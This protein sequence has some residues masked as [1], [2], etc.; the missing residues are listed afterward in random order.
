M[1]MNVWLIKIGEPIPVEAVCKER[2][3]RTGL[4]S[5]YLS[6]DDHKVTWWTS[7]FDRIRRKNIQDQ[8]LI[9]NTRRGLTIR[10][11][12]SPGYN[13]S[14]SMA[15]I[16][17][18]RY[19]AEKFLQCA[20]KESPPD[21]ILSAY[22]TIEL[23]KAAVLYGIQHD[24]PVV[25]DIRDLWPDIF[26]DSS[27]WFVRPLIRILIRPM[28]RDSRL[29]CARAA[30]ITGITEQFVDWGINRGGRRRTPLDRS[31][32]LAFAEATLTPGDIEESK[33]FWDGLGVKANDD[34]F[35]ICF[36]G[37]LGHQFDIDTAVLASRLLRDA[38]RRV[39]F[40]FCGSGDR[41][42]YYRR[43]AVD[44]DRIIFPGWM[45]ASRLHVLLHRASVGLNPLPDRFDFLSTINNKAIEYLSAGLPILSSPT[46]GVLNEFI[47]REKCGRSY[48]RQ[49]ATDLA[50]Q[51]GNL[52]DDP[53]GLRL[54][55]DNARRSFERHFD[56]DQ[57]YPEMIRHLEQ[58]RDSRLSHGNA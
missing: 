31:F 44:D 33:Q 47:T 22:P 40:V 56:P 34:A 50:L 24:I 15:R 55:S 45:N 37:T 11:L 35:I 18:Q 20:V 25:L 41:L 7:T 51:I 28:I 10:L 4:L 23:S 2:I 38:G 14:M 27:P 21:L 16:R 12:Y 36:V 42:E 58:I 52:I 43:M 6:K 48:R 3:H 5:R 8:D 39:L 54:M 1:S 53:V 46:R 26:I 29:V 30:A 13:K 17:D 9:V 49:S 57:V 19:L 32:P